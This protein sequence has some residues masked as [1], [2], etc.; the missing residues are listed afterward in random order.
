LAVPFLH[1]HLRKQQRKKNAMA[2]QKLAKM[3]VQLK[4]VHVLVQQKKT[5]NQMHSWS[6]LKGYV[7]S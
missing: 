3:T 6:F 7:A 4:Q 2:Y 5:T 1:Q